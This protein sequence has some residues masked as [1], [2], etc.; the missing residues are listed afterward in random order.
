MFVSFS[1]AQSITAVELKSDETGSGKLKKAP[2]KI[3]I[4]EFRVNY[5]LL[6]MAEDHKD[7]DKDASDGFVSG[8]LDVV[9]ALG[10]N[11]LTEKDLM[12]NTNHIYENFINKLKSAGYQVMTAPDAAGIKEFADWERKQ[13]GT[14]NP[15][16][17]KG[18][19]TATPANF[20]YFVKKTKSDG[21]EKGTFTDNSPKISFQ[22]K[23]PT[24]IRVNLFV[25]I[26]ENGESWASGAILQDAATKVVLSTNLSLEKTQ[27]YVNFVNSEAMSLPT[28]IHNYTL[29]N[30]IEI[31]GVIEKK[32][33]KYVGRQNHAWSYGYGAL[34]VFSVQDIFMKKVEPI[35][36]DAKKYNAGVRMACDAYL[37]AATDEFLNKTKK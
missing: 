29:K 9:L 34:S 11:G 10:L 30:N 13:G 37:N 35:D 31:G 22:L 6:H 25:P 7:G 23:N 3:Y 17:F 14:L 28:S 27:S 5:Q 8:D 1:V 12:E 21:K 36:V 18:F 33:Y 16:Q 2:R 15:S 32:K 20:E 19:I 4:S 26:A 24:V